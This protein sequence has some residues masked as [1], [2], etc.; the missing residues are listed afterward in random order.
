MSTS[1][2]IAPAAQD[3]IATLFV[4]FE[5]S[6]AT[7]LIGLY[8]PQ[9]GKT[10]SRYKLDGGDINA[11]LERITVARLRLEKL[12]KPVR[13]VSVYEAG[14]DGFWLHRRLTAAGIE[15]RVVDAASIPV[16]RRSRRR[17][18][19]RIDLELLIR[20][21]LALE[22]GETRICRVVQVPTP[23][24]EDAK[25]EHRE[26]AVL[27]KEK[28]AHTNR[29][30]GILMALGIRGVNPHRRD[31]VQRLDGLMTGTGEPLPAH[32][33]QALARE[34]E[35]LIL[36]ERQIKDI[37]RAQA[38]AIKAVATP[39]SVAEE[40]GR[41][42]RGGAQAAALV[43]LKGIGQIS[44]VPLCREVF[45]RHFNN[46]R[47]LAS[48]FGLPPSPYNSGTMRVDQG[49]S[50]AGNPRARRLAIEIAWL[51]IRHQPNST[52]SKWFAQRVGEAKG[53]IRRIAVVALA[54][55]LMVA[56]W[57]YLETGL[58]PEGAVMNAAS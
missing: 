49:I 4:G 10:I 51:W 35:R 6:K 20:M 19:D 41:A 57:R 18:T 5:L 40:G 17:K 24:E 2:L 50:K 22:R 48:Y 21:L 14:Y 28:T 27:V 37:E 33:K 39:Q 23:T 32:T 31:F 52:L 46:R 3:E 11:A 45:Y 9:L 58:I 34:H 42:E 15:N 7:W 53:R 8:S 54:R 26:R 25:R 29:I 38:S 47:E 1:A 55:K 16:E 44:G 43:R 12:G 30:G 13:V 56:L 36:A